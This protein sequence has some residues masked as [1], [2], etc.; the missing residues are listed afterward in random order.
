[1]TIPPGCDHCNDTGV[2]VERREGTRYPYSCKHCERGEWVGTDRS[3]A[4][5]IMRREDPPVA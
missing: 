4:Y 3:L 2:I 5:E 1:M